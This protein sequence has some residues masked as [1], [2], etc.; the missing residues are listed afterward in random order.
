MFGY[1]LNIQAAR[2]PE[3]TALVFGAARLTYAAQNLKPCR[4]PNYIELLGIGRGDRVA[5]ACNNCHHFFEVFFATAKLGAVFVPV[6]F[7]LAAREIVPILEDCQPR[8]L[9]LGNTLSSILPELRGSPACP[10][11]VI[12][13]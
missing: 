5:A 4:L 8:I 11:H 3:A 9:F 12:A 7:R 6:N 13:I 10:E 2:R 1:Q